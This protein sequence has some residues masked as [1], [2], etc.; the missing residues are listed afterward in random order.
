[1]SLAVVR[2]GP[3]LRLE[4]EP[5]GVGVRRHPRTIAAEPV[6]PGPHQAPAAPVIVECA[7]RQPQNLLLLIVVQ[8]PV[9]I[10]VSS[11]ESIERRGIDLPGCRADHRVGAVEIA[12]TYGGKDL[13]R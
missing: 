1:M 12:S 10:L 13:E 2:R 4:R 9:Q 5:G 8:Y 6:Q 7:R 3:D 11:E